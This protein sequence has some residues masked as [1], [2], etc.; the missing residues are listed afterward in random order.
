MTLFSTVVGAPFQLYSNT[1][2]LYDRYPSNTPP[3]NCMQDNER[4]SIFFLLY[5]FTTKT[6]TPVFINY[7]CCITLEALF[8]YN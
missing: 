6:Y 8:K 2:Q 5:C 3:L 1:F 4:G 7:L